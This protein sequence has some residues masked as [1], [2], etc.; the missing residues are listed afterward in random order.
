MSLQEYLGGQYNHDLEDI[1]TIEEVLAEVGATFT[2]SFDDQKGC[3]PYAL[4]VGDS[5]R[6]GDPSQGTSAMI[7]AAIGKMSG[8]C[9]LRDGSPTEKLRGLPSNLPDVLVVSAALA[10]QLKKR[11]KVRSGTFG[12]NEPLTTSHVTE[13]ARGL[14]KALEGR[15]KRRL[16]PL[17]RLVRSTI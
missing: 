16:I 2:A 3:W 4:K 9:T 5:T 15:L 6:S 8:R 12:D 14:R 7:L 17:Q 11:R 13:L 10:K 1:G